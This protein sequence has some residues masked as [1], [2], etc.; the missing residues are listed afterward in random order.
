MPHKMFQMTRTMNVSQHVRHTPTSTMMCLA[1]LKL[2]GSILLIILL[3]LLRVL[4]LCDR[5]KVEF[6]FWMS[7]QCL[8]ATL[9]M[10]RFIIMMQR[11]GKMKFID[12][13]YN[14]YANGNVR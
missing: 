6:L 13:W 1:A 5:T 9:Y 14:T 7:L 2:L 8:D 3:L 12:N 11:S 4:L 10:I